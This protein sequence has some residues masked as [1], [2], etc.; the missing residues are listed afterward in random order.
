MPMQP[1]YDI[2]STGYWML[3]QS[4]PELVTATTGD[5]AGTES[6]CDTACTKH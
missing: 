5:M 4:Y 3:G 1:M 6:E 2:I